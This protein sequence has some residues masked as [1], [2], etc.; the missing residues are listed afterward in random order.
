M[1]KE[2]KD[3]SKNRVFRLSDSVVAEMD[4]LA[5]ILTEETGLKHSRADVL[6]VAVRDLSKKL[7]N[8]RKKR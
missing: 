8:G 6:R 1:A 3:V 7:G 4:H 2:A 5:E